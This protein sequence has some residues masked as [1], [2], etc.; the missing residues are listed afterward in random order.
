MNKFLGL[1]LIFAL[2]ACSGAGDAPEE[3]ASDDLT[4]M[5]SAARKE[6]NAY[7][8]DAT[9]APLQVGCTPY[10]LPPIGSYKG[11]VL[12]IHGFSACPQQYASIAKSLS[13]QG[14]QVLVP[15]M[16]GHGRKFTRDAKGVAIDVTADLPDDEHY[17][18]YRTFAKRMADVVAKTPGQH[19]VMGLSVGG[20]V[21]A[22]AAAQAPGVFQRAL[23]M[24]AFFDISDPL[25]AKLVPVA[26]AIAPEFP[27]GW[28]EKC[29]VQR[30]QGRAGF[31]TFKVTNLRAAQ[32]FGQETL[33][34]VSKIRATTQV[35]GVEED[36]AASNDAIVSAATSVQGSSACF[37]E[38][39]VPHS[40]FSRQD[41]PN[42]NM[43]WL[44]RAE[45][46]VR[47]FLTTGKSFEPSGESTVSGFKRCRSR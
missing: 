38:K 21:A 26:N 32:H 41:N 14:Y 3:A 5:G 31:C 33:A 24:N 1:P 8:L 4:R 47:D 13:G 35:V 36:G 42:V 25:A 37:F 43:Y 12:L 7:M 29:E 34:E 30:S 18:E 40:T 6:W 16:P 11:T 9:V 28:G 39:G 23:V 27:Y 15:L 19:A 17:T 20:A 44:P 46:S 10:A 45:Q 22:S 2:A